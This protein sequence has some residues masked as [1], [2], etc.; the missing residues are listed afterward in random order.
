M[1][2]ERAMGSGAMEKNRGTENRDL[3]ENGCGNE[4]HKERR[5]HEE[6]L[7]TETFTEGA[8]DRNT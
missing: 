7:Q 4:A 2:N 1:K 5:K 8:S 3:Y 6:V